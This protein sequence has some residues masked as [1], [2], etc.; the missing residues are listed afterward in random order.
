M[1]TGLYKNIASF[2][3]EKSLT[4]LYRA[5]KIFLKELNMMAIS[6]SYKNIFNISNQDS[7]KLAKFTLGYA[8]AYQ[9]LGDILFTSG[10]YS[11]SKENIQKFD[12][13][14][15]ERVYSIIYS[16]LTIKEK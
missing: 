3:K 4:F 5:P 9:L 8:Y 10:D 16:E 2:V 7:N 12:E 6:N 14:I 15:Y 13:I 11:L 1:M